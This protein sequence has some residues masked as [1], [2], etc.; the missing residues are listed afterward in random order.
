V[1][2]VADLV[3]NLP[4]EG[5]ATGCRDVRRKTDPALKLSAG[6]HVALVALR[7][8]PDDR[9]VAVDAA[10]KFLAEEPLVEVLLVMP[11]KS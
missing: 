6:E 7:R 10:G 2:V 9:A 5:C 8:W 4:L 3:D 11:L 1:D